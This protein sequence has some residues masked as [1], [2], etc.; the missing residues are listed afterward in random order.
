MQLKQCYLIENDC[1]KQYV[2]MDGGK[3]KGIVVHSTAANN[4]TLKRYVQPVE[5]QE[6]RQAIL[7]DLGQ[8]GNGNHWNQSKAG[9]QKCVHAFIG[10]NAAGDVETYNTLPFDVVCWGCSSGKNGSY[11]Y[12]P[13]AR[14]QFEICEDDLQDEAYFDAVMREAQEFCAYLCERYGF[15]ERD[16]CSH[17]EAG[18][19]GMASTH[20]DPDYWLA[21]FG[22]DM[23]WFRQCVRDLLSPETD[24]SPEADPTA[25][26]VGDRVLYT[27]KVHYRG[28]NAATGYD[29]VGGEAEIT[30]IYKLGKSKH[31]YHLRHTGEG[32]TVFGYVDAGTFSP[33]GAPVGFAV[34]DRV[35]CKPGVTQYAGGGRMA[36]WVPQATLY[37][38]AVEQDGEVLLVSTE[39]TKAVYTGRVKAADLEKF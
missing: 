26:K 30:E 17:N 16:I 5:G 10:V 1:Y 34:G 35:R 39:S 8:N 32:C 12:N 15:T 21:N 24:D 19:A 38:R 14:V 9:F 22:K 25:F 33:V 28:A 27:G 29:C 20:T 3:P 31:P 18:K 2:K 4:K 7:D 37:V 13:N 36:A 6:N 23:D 11:N